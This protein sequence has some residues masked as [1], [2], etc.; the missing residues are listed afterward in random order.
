MD[1]P[2][3]LSLPARVSQGEPFFFQISSPKPIAG[4]QIEWLSKNIWAPAHKEGD[5]WTILALQGVS[6]ACEPGN[7]PLSATIVTPLKEFRITSNITVTSKEYPK[8]HITLPASMVTPDET[9]LARIRHENT[10]IGEVLSIISPVQYWWPE[11]TRPVPGTIS[12]PF[13]LQ[14]ILNGKPR[15]PHRGVDFRGALGTP[16]GSW[17][18]GI[19][20]LT[21]EHYFGG[22]SVYIDHGLGV[23]SSYL[24]LSE[25]LVAPGEFVVP[26]QSIGLLGSTGRSTAPHL[27]FGLSILGQW[28]NP[29][30]LL[31]SPEPVKPTAKKP[32]KGTENDCMF[33]A[34][35]VETS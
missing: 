26:G 3:Q 7:F 22:R 1:S 6:L 33:L 27:H 35:C 11:F 24:H 34:D 18:A 13:G 21:A 30:L 9:A 5:K 19:V 14:R 28:V 31:K 29:L 32:L 16:V 25:I 15:A 4:A 17:S 12:S 10:M 20:L 8:Q 2:F 23:I